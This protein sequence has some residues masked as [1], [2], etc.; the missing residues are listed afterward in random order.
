MH[1]FLVLLYRVSV[2]QLHLYR[3]FPEAL[4]GLLAYC[5]CFF[6]SIHIIFNYM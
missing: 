4:V 2:K 3:I 5:C 1:Y 6:C